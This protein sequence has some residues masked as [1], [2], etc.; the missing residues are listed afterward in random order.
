MTIDEAIAHALEVA[1]EQ[2]KR[3]DVEEMIGVLDRWGV[4][5]LRECAADHRQLAEWLQELKVAK[6][7]IRVCKRVLWFVL[8]H[9]IKST[10]TRHEVETLLKNITEYLSGGGE[11]AT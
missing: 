9:E 8:V 2:Q 7:I 10:S 4:E 6:G 5:S 3:A 1:G 11:N